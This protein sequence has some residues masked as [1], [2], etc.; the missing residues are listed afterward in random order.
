MLPPVD[1]EAPAA[2][3]TVVNVAPA[4]LAIVAPAA[5]APAVPAGAS[6][7]EQLAAP[8]KQ[9]VPN[10]A[11]TA[12]WRLRIMEL[13]QGKVR[14]DRQR[15]ATATRG[16]ARRKNHVS[17]C[18]NWQAALTSHRINAR[19]SLFDP[20]SKGR[21]SRAKFRDRRSLAMRQTRGSTPE[22]K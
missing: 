7:D 18:R 17:L 9:E 20:L 16:A 19:R 14:D 5:L 2:P 8:H 3:A 6:D 13:L 10:A 11:T 1:I 15:A 12:T 22:Q 4:P 21:S